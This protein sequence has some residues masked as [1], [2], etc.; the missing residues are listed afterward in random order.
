MWRLL[1]G[2][3][4]FVVGIIISI[5]RVR[6]W[7]DYDF[8]LAWCGLIFILD[9]ISY[10]LSKFSIFFPF[11]NFLLLAFSSSVMWWFYEAVNIY[12]Q[13][14]I[15]PVKKLYEPTEYGV[16]STIAFT[17]IIPFL[18]LTSSIVRRLLFRGKIKWESG[19][20]G[21]NQKYF[22]ITLG[23]LSLLLNIFIPLYTFPLVWAVI[24]FVFDPLNKRRSLFYQVFHKN[25]KPFFILLI[26]GIFAGLIWESMNTL[27]PK[28]QYPIVSWFWTLPHPITTKLGEMPLGGFI[29]YMPFMLSVFAFVEFLELKKDWFKD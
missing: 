10:R 27:I 19:S 18:I 4:L 6:P 17:T 8:L 15:Y 16:F 11:R 1:F 28:W 13:N 25:L 22:I 23:F 5:P 14:W 26:S 20:I 21:K 24:F 3:V 2:I 12:L 7:L 9:F 29:G